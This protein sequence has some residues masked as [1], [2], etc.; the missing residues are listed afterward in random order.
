MLMLM[1]ML[2]LWRRA[3]GLG[4]K[5]GLRPPLGGRVALACSFMPCAW[6]LKSLQPD[7]V[8]AHM[9]PSWASE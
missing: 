9:M 2:M 4:G 7:G 1:L 6:F 5:L 3:L 8:R